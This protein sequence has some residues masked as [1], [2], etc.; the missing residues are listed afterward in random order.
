MEALGVIGYAI[1]CFF[2]VVY[3][4]GIRTKLGT[5]IWTI[6]T[7]LFFVVSA[8]LILLLDANLIWS[9]VFL[10]AG[11]IVGYLSSFILA[12]EVPILAGSLHFIGSLYAGILRVGIS[13]EEVEAAQKASALEAIESFGKK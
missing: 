3:S 5:G 2:G 13:P 7:A 4:V 10:V 8:V 11:F 6:L 12:W 1:L 9:W